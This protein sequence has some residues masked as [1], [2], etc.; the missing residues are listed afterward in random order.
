VTRNQTS[1]T[2]ST[3]AATALSN[4]IGRG[5]KGRPVVGPSFAST[6]PKASQPSES[7][8]GPKRPGLDQQ[9]HCLHIAVSP[10]SASAA[11]TKAPCKVKVTRRGL[12][13]NDLVDDFRETIQHVVARQIEG[14]SLT[15]RS[16]GR[17]LLPS[18]TQTRQ[19]PTQRDRIQPHAPECK[20]RKVPMRRHFLTRVSTRP[21]A[22]RRFEVLTPHQRRFSSTAAILAHCICARGARPRP[23]AIDIDAAL[24]SPQAHLAGS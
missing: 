4:R 24:P 20:M 23:M 10:V 3:V 14:L 16:A 5:P 21:N 6:E 15:S 2:T 1:T 17:R 13:G 19:F 11:S 7:M 9:P 8:P 12:V 22:L 18:N